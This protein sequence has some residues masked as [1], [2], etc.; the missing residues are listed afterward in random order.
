MQR[1]PIRL[2]LVTRGAAV[3]AG[4]LVASLLA[5]GCGGEEPLPQGR[6]SLRVIDETTGEP[7][8]ARVE[9]RAADGSFAVPSAA[10]DLTYEC[11][12]APP[13]EWRADSVVD[14]ALPNPHSGTTQFMLA[15]P[16]VL[17]V[18][19]GEVSVK[20]WRGIEWLAGEATVLAGTEDAP[21]EVT[22]ELRRWADEPAR[23]WYGADDHIHVTRRTPADD[24]RIASWM[25]GEDLHLANL[26]Q[27]GTAAQFSV[28]P[29]RAFGPEGV[30]RSDPT[31]LLVPGQEHPRTHFFGHTITLGA[32]EAI[33]LR[34]QYALYEAFAEA[35]Q[36]KG[37]LFGFAHWG[38]G[39]A[40][41][42]LALT[43]P[44]G[45]VSF[46]EVLQF[47]WTNFDPWY[48]MLD[49]GYRIA[50]TAGTDFPC[51]PW[52]IPGRERFYTKVEGPLTV[53]GWL[54]GIRNGRTYVT[55]GPLLELAVEGV[56]PGGDVTLA[57]PGTLRVQ[58]TVRFD[59]TRDDVSVVE[60]VVDGVAIPLVTTK[61][62]PGL[63]RF[64][65]PVPVETSGWLALRANGSKQGEAPLQPMDA[66]DWVLELIGNIADGAQGF[67]ERE[68]HM[69]KR[70]PRPSAAHTGAV[71]VTVD[72]TPPAGQGPRALERA[73]AIRAR[74]DDLEAR[75]A[76]DAIADQTIWDWV[77]YSDGLPEEQLRTHREALLRSI[78]ASRDALP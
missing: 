32:R 77:P 19:A 10:L 60:A 27:M 20:A 72:G 7:L 1:R 56:G 6:L 18:P 43:A 73:A 74:L 48:A 37:G 68:A 4:L 28:T 13:S 55:N 47:E 50:P 54:E 9:I 44:K 38:E 11:E 66:P 40:R 70:G 61:A 63:L 39:V 25:Q 45:G 59:P 36:E 53:E 46:I 62:G 29:Q 41:D 75:L 2:A 16:A 31:H 33:D 24:V 35:A 34:D 52:S 76:P 5:T 67:E 51:G 3:L 22:L 57:A 78:D 42:G 65:Q 64:D 58:G 15:G 17:E 23:G 8:A 69:S 26:L 30:V 21:A 71:W 14:K 49:L 12:V